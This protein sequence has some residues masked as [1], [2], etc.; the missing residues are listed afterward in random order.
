MN[1][2]LNI[3]LIHILA[4]FVIGFIAIADR[5]L[6]VRSGH[7]WRKWLWCILCIRLIL[8]VPL[9]L[10]LFGDR[11]PEAKV[12]IDVSGIV[13]DLPM[14]EASAYDEQ[15]ESLTQS[16]AMPQGR[17]NVQTRSV[18]WT[19]VYVW[20]AGV[21]FFLRFRMSQYLHT[22]KLYLETAVACTDE[23]LISLE[24]S[25]G[26][27]L[28]IRHLPELFVQEKIKSPMVFGYIYCKL[29]I[30]P[31]YSDD[32]LLY[33][34]RHELTHKKKQDIWYKLLLILI[35]DIYWFNPMLRLMKK[36]AFLDVEYVCD[37]SVIKNM[38]AD[39]KKIYAKVILRTVHMG[40]MKP[41][42]LSTQFAASKSITRKRLENLFFDHDLNRGYIVLAILLG[43]F[44]LANVCITVTDSNGTITLLKE[45]V[46]I[47]ENMETNAG[48]QKAE[49]SPPFVPDKEEVLRKR[50]EIKASVDKENYEIIQK[51][52]RLANLKLEHWFLYGNIFS[53]MEDPG[54]LVWNYIDKKGEIQTGWAYSMDG[55][56]DIELAQADPEQYGTQVVTYNPYNGEDF[57]D[58]MEELKAAVDHHELR[59]DFERMISDME[60]AM[61][62]HDV[63]YIQDIYY[64]LHDMDYFL[65][66]YG[67]EVG[68]YS[69][70]D[71]STVSKYYGVL[72]IYRDEKE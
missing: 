69:I 51:I 12:S 38:P 50:E 39:E 48:T 13:P 41:L 64:T 5:F 14:S 60:N 59:S 30:P 40:S 55:D 63:V 57:V 17:Q 24:K 43:S 37:E 65:F 71:R 8:P 7:T 42:H 1:F 3:F 70:R 36:K 21:L 16:Y 62:T 54:D 45:S 46:T 68:M 20:A 29:L 23:R 58:L 15:E 44:C 6:T 18:L 28:G 56:V 61:D 32:E 2:I 19:L 33:V 25:V 72:N 52:V 31:M 49:L 35:C 4:D 10:R 67:P 9:S 22:C 66:R 53:R 26:N 11:W 27:E 34:M 47:P